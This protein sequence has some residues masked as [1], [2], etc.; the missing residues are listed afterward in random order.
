MGVGDWYL[1]HTI[2]GGFGLV[3]LQYAKQG[4]YRHRHYFH[5]IKAQACDQAWY[6]F[7]CFYARR[8]T[9]PEGAGNCGRGWNPLGL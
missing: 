1:I 6:H 2:A 9:G 5:G 7:S 8:R 3:A 4:R